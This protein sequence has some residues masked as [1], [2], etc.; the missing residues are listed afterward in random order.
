MSLLGDFV[1]EGMD[2]INGGGFAVAVGAGFGEIRRW[3]R[4]VELILPEH[5]CVTKCVSMAM[6]VACSGD[7]LT[8]LSMRI[9]KVRNF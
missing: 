8:H 5:L 1:N 4:L 6:V 9:I 2:C 3:E 7:N